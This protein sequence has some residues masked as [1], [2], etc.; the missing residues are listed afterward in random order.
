MNPE[1]K[2]C[3]NCKKDFTIETEDF[4]FYEKIKV[5]PPTWCPECRLIRRLVWRNDRYLSKVTCDLCGQMTL[6]T[7]P[8]EKGRII[9]CS[10]CYRSDKWD[11]MDYGQ[12]YDF[13]KPFFTQFK[14]LMQKVPSRALFAS[15]GTLVNSEYTNLVSH[16]K[17]CYLIY[18]SDYAEN[19]MYG[20]E[21]ENSKECVDN[22]MIDGGEQNYE[23]VNCQKCFKTFFSTDCIESSDI[24]FSYD[25]VGCLN[26]FGCVG[27]RNKNY[28]I[29]NQPYSRQDYHTKVAELFTGELTE[30]A[31]IETK[32]REIYLRTPR[33]YMH[34]RQ[35]VKVSGDYIYNSKEVTN[36][37]I[38]VGAQ[39]CKY[40]MWLIVPPVKDCWDYTEYG[41]RAEEIYETVTAGKGVAR[42][43]FCNMVSSNCSDSEYSYSSRDIHYAFGCNALKKKSYCILNK[44]YTKEEYEELLPKIKKHM[45]DVPYIDEQ[46]RV[47]KYG[48]FFPFE[49]SPFPYNQ[50]SAQEFFPLDKTAIEKL[51]CRYEEIKNRD[52][53]VTR[54]PE[55]LPSKINE[56]DDSILK[57]VIGCAEW[58]SEKSKIQN[59]TMAFRLTQNELAFYRKHNLPLPRKCPNCRHFDR[60]KRRNPIT[61]WHRP[62]MKEGC[63]NEFETSY[64][65]DRPEIVYCEQ[66]YQQ[67][68][69]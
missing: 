66:H 69:Y 45:D 13:S 22:T 11:P 36:S 17:N 62:C 34:G 57:E 44:Q 25:L 30:I 51:G 29:F 4:N 9:Y 63:K 16:L 35:N 54:K 41:D 43:K 39:N 64:A 15:G 27:L 1:T 7:F 19:C 49:L 55:E 61:L 47:Y 3:Q 38:G 8:K 24:W 67:A 46:E 65:P 5:P 33:R 10:I 23:D 58:G 59:C 52:Y 68:I 28:Y 6:S 37:Y 60:I 12:S 2:S 40:S 31:E 50:S 26:C 48:E 21:I 42:L 56:V 14:E 53:V 18:N 20:S 32:V